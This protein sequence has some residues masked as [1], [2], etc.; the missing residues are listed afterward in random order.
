MSEPQ[1][2]RVTFGMDSSG[3]EYVP[4]EPL[5]LDGLLSFCMVEKSPDYVP[6]RDGEPTEL[7]LPLEKFETSEG[8]CWKASCLMPEGW[9]IETTR[10]LRRKFDEGLSALTTGKP[11][12][13][14]LR[15]KDRNDPHVFQLCT[16]LTG[17]MA[18]REPEVVCRELRK[19]KYL[20]RGKA[21]GNGRIQSI[22]FQIVNEDKTLFDNGICTRY[23]PHPKGW[24]FVRPRPEYWRVQGRCKCFAPGDSTDGLEDCN[25]RDT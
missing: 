6:E 24:K 22:D 23:I 1:I 5:H 9:N 2:L 4:M 16:S 15:Y 19:L 7:D 21:R 12:L 14:G 10:N 3:I 11:N 25:L 20:G 17:Y 8:W 18:T 13:I